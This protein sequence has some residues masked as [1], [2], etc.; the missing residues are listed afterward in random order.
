MSY[1]TNLLVYEY[2][3]IELLERLITATQ[4]LS[5]LSDIKVGEV[6]L[7]LINYSSEGGGNF[8]YPTGLAGGSSPS[9]NPGQSVG[10]GSNNPG[11]NSNN[12]GNGSNDSGLSPEAF[13]DLRRSVAAKLRD[14]FIN[15]PTGARL[16]MDDINYQDRINAMDHN[17]VCKHILDTG[18]NLRKNIIVKD[19]G[20]GAVTYTGYISLPLLNLLG[21]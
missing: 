20:Q 10:S 18:S 1:N 7:P 11:G 2:S 6:E 3:S 12:S 5:D 21:G 13:D 8:S 17:V 9:S 15:R 4:G 16:K 19:N 14:I